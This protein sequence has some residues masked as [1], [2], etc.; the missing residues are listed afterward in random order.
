MEVKERVVIFRMAC[1]SQFY[2]CFV[3]LLRFKDGR[4]S[5]ESSFTRYGR[6][7]LVVLREFAVLAPLL[8]SLIY[9]LLRTLRS[10]VQV[11]H[12]Q[13]QIRHTR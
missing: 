1:W 5:P 9:T 6:P 10:T 12:N 2:S 4:R 13:I 8:S 7:V 11:H 3:E